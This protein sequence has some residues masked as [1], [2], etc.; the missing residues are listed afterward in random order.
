MAELLGPR[1]GARL[2]SV[3]QDPGPLRA[4]GW[5]QRDGGVGVEGI[6]LGGGR[7]EGKSKEGGEPRQLVAQFWI[8]FKELQSQWRDWIPLRR[9]EGV[10]GRGSGGGGGF[11]GGKRGNDGKTRGKCKKK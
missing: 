11:R 2:L 8:T 3:E 4:E 7:R 5:E 10:G 1:F 6:Q 9:E